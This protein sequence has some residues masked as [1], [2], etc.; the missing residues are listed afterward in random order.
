MIYTGAIS[1][2]LP[3]IG[4]TIF[5]EMSALAEQHNAINLSQGFPDFPV[6]PELID[7]VYSNMKKGVNQYAP[8]AGLLPLRERISEMVL[9][10]YGKEYNPDTEITVTAGAT[11]GIYTAI[12]AFVKE[13]DEVIIFTPAYDCYQPAIELNGGR[14][15]FV[16]LQSPEYTIDW[17]EVKKVI[18]RKTRMII[19][20]TPHNP[21]GKVLSEEDMKTLEK[22]TNDSDILILSD[23]V[24]EHII[25]D[26]VQHQSAS[27]FPGLA[28]RSLI[29]SSF[30]KTFHVTGWKIGYC[31]G[32]ENLMK[33]F[34]KVHQFLVFS[35]NSPMQ[36]AFAEF[37]KKEENY[38]NLSDFY[39]KKRDTFCSLIKNSN[40]KFIPSAGTYFQL[41]DYSEI[42][43]DRD[44]NFAIELTK[45]HKIASI[46]ISVFY[47]SPEYNNVLR[48]CFAKD[49]KTLE[50]AAKILNSL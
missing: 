33:E 10:K 22:V 38:L 30:G 19:I 40:F 26:Q 16:K 34:R 44:I 6:S 48:F 2:K 9:S 18:N 29:V 15:I 4:Q 13:D 32:P 12:S 47:H 27:R 49:D 28:E 25:F 20:N 17:E 24:Y 45:K 46:P 14:A 8:M 39:Q 5:S 35:V 31:L 21:T 11:Q 1:S 36:A 41:L 23:E 37:I 43:T 3:K 50:S 42:S 7:M